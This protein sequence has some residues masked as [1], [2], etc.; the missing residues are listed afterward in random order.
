MSI[1]GEHPLDVS[2]AEHR[3]D[4]TW[5]LFFGHSTTAVRLHF[6]RQQFNQP[7]TKLE[8]RDADGQVLQTFDSSTPFSRWSDVYPVSYLELRYSEATGM[9]ESTDEFFID[10][11]RVTR[12]LTQEF[13][14]H[15]TGDLTVTGDTPNAVVLQS[16]TQDKQRNEEVRAILA[17]GEDQF[18][19]AEG[20]PVNSFDFAVVA[21]QRYWYDNNRDLAYSRYF[22]E[23]L[24]G[25]FGSPAG[26]AASVDD[27]AILSHTG[28]IFLSLNANGHF[29]GFHLAYRGPRILR[30]DA[31]AGRVDADARE[32]LMFVRGRRVLTLR[33]AG[34][35][36][37]PHFTFA[38]VNLPVYVGTFPPDTSLRSFAVD[39]DDNGFLDVAVVVNVPDEPAFGTPGYN[40]PA[41]TDQIR[42]FLN[43]GT[44]VFTAGPTWVKRQLGR[45]DRERY[46]RFFLVGDFDGD[47]DED[48]LI[49]DRPRRYDY[50]PTELGDKEVYRYVAL[51]RQGAADWATKPIEDFS[52]WQH[53]KV[54]TPDGVNRIPLHTVPAEVNG[55]ARTDLLTLRG[56]EDNPQL[57]FTP[58]QRHPGT[59][60]PTFGPTS[61]LWTGRTRDGLTPIDLKA[62][63]SDDLVYHDWTGP[64]IGVSIARNM[65][66]SYAHAQNLLDYTWQNTLGDVNNDGYADLVMFTGDTR[67]TVEVFL[68]SGSTGRYGMST[69]WATEFGRYWK[70]PDS[71]YGLGLETARIG[72]VDGDGLKDLVLFNFANRPAFPPPSE[73]ASP[74]VGVF[75]AKNLGGSFAPKERWNTSIAQHQTPDLPLGEASYHLADFDR[76]GRAD[77]AKVTVKAGESPRVRVALSRGDRFGP[78]VDSVDWITSLPGP[79]PRVREVRAQDVTGDGRSDFVLVDLISSFNPLP[80]ASGVSVDAYAANGSGGFSSAQPAFDHT[81]Q[82]VIPAHGWVQL[83]N[84]DL[85]ND[86][87]VALME[88]INPS[89]VRTW[90]SINGSGPLQ[91]MGRGLEEIPANS[92]S[93]LFHANVMGDR[94]EEVIAF[95]PVEHAFLIARAPATY[96]DL[97]LY[98]TPLWILSSQS[99][100]PS[101]L[102]AP[103]GGPGTVE[104]A[105]DFSS[106]E[107][108][109]NQEN[110]TGDWQLR[111]HNKGTEWADYR[112]LS[113]RVMSRI[114]LDVLFLIQP[115]V[116]F[117]TINHY[118]EKLLGFSSNFYDAL[119]GRMRIDD[120]QLW[121]VDTSQGGKVSWWRD[122]KCD[123]RID[124]FLCGEDLSLCSE[125]YSSLP[126]EDRDRAHANSDCHMTLFQHHH[127]GVYVHEFGHFGFAMEDE[128][129]ENDSDTV[130][131]CGQG[132]DDFSA[133][134]CPHSLMADSGAREF[135]TNMNHQGFG[136]AANGNVSQWSHIPLFFGGIFNVPRA[137][138]AGTPN[139][140][141][142]S[143]PVFKS[144]VL[145]H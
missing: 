42:F 20:T 17:G 104:S 111:V 38:S 133:S 101:R 137:D 39:I 108:L 45:I 121:A 46:D 67:G 55:D 62:T 128:Y 92:R 116:G 24:A 119:D 90:L 70:Q 4:Y 60:L 37:Y 59:F 1:V 69:T 63:G 86:I 58:A 105:T 66:G 87:D 5:R 143:E 79:L 126:V 14:N 50:E 98:A 15:P 107:L 74:M 31:R 12:D 33:A 140:H 142:Y 100:P 138:P 36:E 71:I 51:N 97:D 41:Q 96:V 124:L 145:I 6:L 106:H 8:V 85:D 73:S 3:F 102:V 77:A 21:D 81:V 144:D 7:N 84:L 130:P 109:R 25:D 132:G 110:P 29:R 52:I 2:G 129:C 64:F 131:G 123:E 19:L 30:D 127:P 27:L 47:G 82:G 44:G 13:S 48:L 61:I 57:F 53:F 114:D 91:D 88:P 76:D 49:E 32:D 125:D 72:D 54:R 141:R 26:V 22:F 112:L 34:P 11:V 56:P 10:M 139:P 78:D 83:A 94:R 28:E 99:F 122:H 120:F 118:R 93:T 23:Y 16:V 40:D 103:Y 35:P 43:D 136:I 113:N 115:P 75:V 68:A 117:E 134:V 95:L 9:G 80:G 18:F 89:A 65:S 135:C